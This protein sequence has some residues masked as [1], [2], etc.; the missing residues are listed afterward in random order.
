MKR[1]RVE[2]AD[3]AERSN[4]ALALW[5]AA[6]GK[7]QRPAVAAFLADA[8][9][10]LAALSR[11]ILAAGDTAPPTHAALGLAGRGLPIGA[12]TSQHFAN[13][14]LGVA[15]RLLMA[16]PG[17]RAH[18][19]YMDDVV[20]LCDSPAAAR[21]SL[22][23]LRAFL[24]ERLGL[25]LKP[26]AQPLP[27]HRGLRF[28][29]YRVKPGVVLAGP[30]KMKRARAQAERLKVAELQGWPQPLL[31]RAQASQAAALLPAQSQRFQRALWWPE[32]PARLTAGGFLEGDHL[33]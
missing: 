12:L 27:S 14:Y 26:G 16:H 11:R 18:V 15:D 32:G 7:R 21:D 33:S 10:R 17:V 25:M 6:R 28:C 19:R 8:D 20:W 4:L 5:K 2:L 29:G 30:R 22:A 24:P 9:A 23:A 13:H 3:L 1:Q 31:Q